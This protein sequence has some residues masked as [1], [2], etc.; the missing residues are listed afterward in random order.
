MPTSIRIAGC[1]GVLLA[2]GRAARLGGIP[3]GLLLAGGEP[4]VQRSLR[5][6]REIFED[7]LVVTNEPGPY[8]GF[9]ARI[10][11]DA[12][13][14]KGAPG[15]VHAALAAARTEWIFLAGCDMPSL[16]R[17]G[18]E[19]LAGL[20]EGAGA[21]AVVWQGQLEPLHAFWSRRGLAEIERLLRQGDPSMW[22]LARAAGARLVEEAEWRRIDPEGRAFANANTPE[23]AAR[24][25]L[26]APSTGNG[27]GPWI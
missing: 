25:G 7:V 12:I 11:P 16:S 3:K 17:P 22:A 14:G 13:A 4:I 26:A 23:D 8:D 9:G 18:I 2:G 5:L 27:S 19:F 1:T 20:R 15:G 6:F 10:V 24:L 21:V